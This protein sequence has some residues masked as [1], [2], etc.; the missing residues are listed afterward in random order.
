MTNKD[1]ICTLY[2]NDAD[3]N[4]QKYF[5]HNLVDMN[6]KEVLNKKFLHKMSE[7]QIDFSKNFHGIMNIN[8]NYNKTLSK[9]R[10]LKEKNS[11][12]LF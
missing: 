4:I 3:N 12:P 2:F 10:K 6:N 11:K 8:L 9:E 1:P 7:V 5:L